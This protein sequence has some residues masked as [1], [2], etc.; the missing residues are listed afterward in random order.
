MDSERAEKLARV[1][2]LNLV[3]WRTL[4]CLCL[5]GYVSWVSRLPYAWDLRMFVQAGDGDMKANWVGIHDAM[6]AM[7]WYGNK[8]LKDTELRNVTLHGKE[9]GEIKSVDK[10]TFM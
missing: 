4:V 8:T 6:V 1:S 3:N 10:F 7:P 9:V 5:F 2:Y